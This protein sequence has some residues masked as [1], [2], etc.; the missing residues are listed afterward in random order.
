MR[1][2]GSGALTGSC[3]LHHSAR[4]DGVA[5]ATVAIIPNAMMLSAAKRNN[6]IYTS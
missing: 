2:E 5:L 4:R 1:L 6:F 3:D